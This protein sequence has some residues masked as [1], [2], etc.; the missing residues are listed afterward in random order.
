MPLQF[1]GNSCPGSHV[2]SHVILRETLRETIF[3]HTLCACVKTTDLFL[4][5]F[6]V[7]RAFLR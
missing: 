2:G 5:D 3:Y 6:E 1:P 4:L 7:P